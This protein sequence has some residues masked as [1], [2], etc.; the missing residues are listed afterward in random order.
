[1]TDLLIEAQIVTFNLDQF[2]PTRSI[3]S[4]EGGGHAFKKS[5]L[6]IK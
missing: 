2:Y 1:M 5:S 3:K 6:F 4:Q